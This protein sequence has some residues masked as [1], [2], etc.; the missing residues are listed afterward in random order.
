MKKMLI[1]FLVLILIMNISV[2]TFAEENKTKIH[3]YVNDTEVLF[4]VQP[5][6]IQSRTMV[7]L[8]AVF[9]AMGALVE[10]D[11]YT[12]TATIT[13]GTKVQVQLD[14]KNA[15]VDG[16]TVI[17]DVPAAG[18]NGRI[19]VPVRFISEALGAVVD[20][21]NNTKTAFINEVTENTTLGN[22]QNRGRF[23]TDGIWNFYILEDGVLIRED[24]ASKKQEKISD[25]IICDLHIF[26]EWIYSIAVDNGIKKVM[27]FQKNGTL[28]EIIVNSPVSSIH[29]I[30]GWI[31]YGDS[32]E[33][34]V[35]YRTGTDGSVTEKVLE[36]GIFTP[37]NWFVQDG[38]VFYKNTNHSICKAR[39]DGSGIKE[40][41]RNA[42][43]YDFKLI[44]EDYIYLTR[45]EMETD[46][47]LYRLTKSGGEPFRIYDKNPITMNSD[48]E[49]LYAAVKTDTGSRLIKMKKDGTE[50]V[51]INEY[52]DNDTPKDIYINKS[53]VY[54]TLLRG[55]EEL[56]FRMSLQGQNITPLSW[57]YSDTY[58]KVKDVLTR[59]SS[60][61]SLINSF[62]SILFTSVQEEGK[63]ETIVTESRINK[64]QSLYHQK[65]KTGNTENDIEIWVDNEY[66]YSRKS[67]ESIWTVD[68]LSDDDT[69]TGKTVYDYILPSQEL[70]NNLNLIEENGKYIL[71]GTGAFPVFMRSF[72]NINANRLY[73]FISDFIDNVNIEIIIS[74]NGYYI[75]ELK[76]EVKYRYE[77]DKGI[78]KHISCNYQYI[79]SQFDDIYL[80]L[81]YLAQQ[82]VNAKKRADQIIAEGLKKSGEGKFKEAIQ[83]FDSALNI[84]NKSFEAWLYKANA[85]YNQND[86]EGAILSYGKYYEFNPSDVDILALQGMCYFE[87]GDFKKAKE[88]AYMVLDI[89]FNSAPAYNLSGLISYRKEEYYE[90]YDSF[91]KAVQLKPQNYEYNF[92]MAS[93][94]YNMGSYTKCIQAVDEMLKQFPENRNLMF[95]K[96]RSLSDQGK[97]NEAIAIFEQILKKNPA[98]DF[99]TMTYI[100]LEYENLQN[101][102]KAQDYADRARG[103]YADYS[104]LKYLIEKLDY[105]RSTSSGERLVNF[106]KEYYLFYK[107]TDEVEKALTEIIRKGNY[108]SIQDVE[109]LLEGIKSYDDNFTYMISGNDF[110]SFVSI[111]DKTNM[112]T[113]QDGNVIYAVIST[114]SPET[115]VQFTEYI[116]SIQDSKEK[117][118]IL[119]LRDNDGGLTSEANKILDALLPDCITSY[120]IERDGYIRSYH[121]AKSKIEFKKIGILVNEKT[122]SSSELVALGL[123][124]YS[125]NVTIIGRPTVGKGVGQTVYIDYA[126]KYALFLVNHYWNILHTN[127]NEKGLPI[128]IAAGDDD[129]EYIKALGQFLKD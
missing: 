76:L 47:G 96:A 20:W 36:D 85:Q 13:K 62:S 2:S 57:V 3:V 5:V 112:V 68:K 19:L 41:L 77:D 67:D 4:D 27:R 104:L 126:K 63:T 113:R 34:R 24:I 93:V 12:K 43:E 128:D 15:L 110:E 109:K 91:E 59:V 16:K 90:A 46:N 29:I 117:I 42:N 121:S 6:F 86:Y 84:Y 23:A 38:W 58:N 55:T 49:N 10:W 74:R 17:M 127:I 73:G 39:I 25:H 80:T 97:S 65:I 64:T 31:Y 122:A 11:N 61:S 88:L 125:D 129:P 53:S 51:T 102:T 70:C 52:K 33:S 72:Y 118:L 98:N 37:K 18:I 69:L 115:G 26:G 120:L 45:N 78:E 8:R 124:L 92:N 105:A 9:E 107:D 35:L 123:K 103:V 94:L 54:Y 75:E 40:L 108:Y 50:A 119:D 71:R 106:I 48:G 116:Q 79:N 89:K 111:N 1:F 99:V 114:F 87:L 7:P 22:I 101:Y 100:G 44:D 95:L 81:P 30:N 60:A 21:D 83:L 66:L 14:N 28:K 32:Q 82:S 56:L